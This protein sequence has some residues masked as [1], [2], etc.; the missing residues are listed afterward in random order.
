[1]NV[2][3]YFKDY[4]RA[5]MYNHGKPASLFEYLLENTPKLQHNDYF[6]ETTIEDFRQQLI[7][8]AVTAKGINPNKDKLII[9]IK[10]VRYSNDNSE[11]WFYIGKK[12]VLLRQIENHNINLTNDSNELYT[13]SIEYNIQI[14]QDC[15]PPVTPP[16]F[17]F[18]LNLIDSKVYMHDYTRESNT[19]YVSWVKP[20]IRYFNLIDFFDSFE[21]GNIFS[22]YTSYVDQ[23]ESKLE[24]EYYNAWLKHNIEIIKKTS[25]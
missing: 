10:C 17:E 18:N 20:F 14:D 24:L 22:K 12:W 6:S 13:D 5:D 4:L 21:G 7:I 23:H 3:K 9:P 15:I 16:V 25:D 11:M 1:M 2:P 8:S 19:I